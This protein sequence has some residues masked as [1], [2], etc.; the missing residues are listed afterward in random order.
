MF[1]S[2]Y[3]AAGRTLS[4]KMSFSSKRRSSAHGNAG[5]KQMSSYLSSGSLQSADGTPAGA[6]KCGWNVVYCGTVPVETKAS[7]AET[8]EASVKKLKQDGE[9]KAFDCASI[10]AGVLA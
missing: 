6:R 8:V 1:D 4:K 10:H 2:L 9:M 7:G 3:A 5:P